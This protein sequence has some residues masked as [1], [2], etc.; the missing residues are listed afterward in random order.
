M[1]ALLVKITFYE[2][3]FKVH[4]TKKFR[5]S[6]PM[7]LPTSVAGIFGAMLGI[8]RIEFEKIFEHLYFGAELLKYD[9]IVIE[10]ATFIQYKKHKTN[11]QT[12][13]AI[14]GTV[15]THIINHPTYLIAAAG[16]EDKIT[17]YFDFLK[18]YKF[19][20]LPYGGQNDFFVEKIEI[21]GLTDVVQDNIVS[22][23]A[24]QDMVE[25]FETKEIVFSILPVM[26]TY[27]NNPNF[28][29]VLKGKLKLKE[30]IKVVEGNN[31]A[32]YPL[33]MFKIVQG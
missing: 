16:K 6:Y 28:Y 10:N 33:R 11:H 25:K 24:P 15:H 19:V 22:N 5:L 14:K 31:I 13:D 17:S 9:G 23:Y 21:K 1:K 26:H 27:S 20:Y 7:P 4:Y 3:F 32:V 29:F 8:D 30:T 12:A 2:A 18:N